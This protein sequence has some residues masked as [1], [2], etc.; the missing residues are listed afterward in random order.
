[1]DAIYQG[2]EM[3]HPNALCPSM[4]EIAPKVRLKVWIICDPT[5]HLVFSFFFS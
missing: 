2:Q 4:D 5:L 1:M 3:N